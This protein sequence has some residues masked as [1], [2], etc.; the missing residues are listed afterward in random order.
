MARIYISSSV[1]DLSEFRVEVYKAVH[2]LGHQSVAMEEWV[3]SDLPPL[4]RSLT[5]VRE[6]DV[7]IVLVAWRCGYI[8]PGQDV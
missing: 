6:S 2:R 7:V 3:A 1:Q 5:E 8:P 4:E